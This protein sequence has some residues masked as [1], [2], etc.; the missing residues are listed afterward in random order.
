MKADEQ[1]RSEGTSRIGDQVFRLFEQAG[2]INEIGKLPEKRFAIVT[3]GV[4][5]LWKINSM[6]KFVE[7]MDKERIRGS[8][9]SPESVNEA[10]RKQ[11]EGELQQIRNNSREWL[12]ASVKQLVETALEKDPKKMYLH[13]EGI[14]FGPDHY[15]TR[16]K[17]AGDYFKSIISGVYPPEQRTS[18]DK[19]IS[20]EREESV[21]QMRSTFNNRLGNVVAALQPLPQE[22][23]K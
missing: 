6:G 22:S 7:K 16:L 12:P 3:D 20:S 23:K 13:K 9:K 10:V 11:V 5:V 4:T 1:V 2:V 19:Y 17:N 18:M 15:I 8:E 14:M 21:Y